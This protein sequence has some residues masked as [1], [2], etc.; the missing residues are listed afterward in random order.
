[1]PIC[2]TCGIAF[3]EGESHHCARQPAP[4]LASAAVVGGAVMGAGFGYLG[5]VAVACLLMDAGNLCGFAGFIFGLPIGGL[6]GGWIWEESRGELLSDIV[7]T[8]RGR[9]NHR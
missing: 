1:M 6:V 8:F 5:V 7:R 4:L 3:L 2:P 9:G